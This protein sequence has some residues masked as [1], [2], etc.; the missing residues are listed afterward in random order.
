M[1]KR[2]IVVISIVL[3]FLHPW[4]AQASS[5]LP[6]APDADTQYKISIDKD[7]LYKITYNALLNAGV[8]VDTIDPRYFHLRNGNQEIPI[9]LVTAVPGDFVAGDYF[10][11]YGQKTNTKYTDTNVYWLS[12]DNL[13]GLTMAASDGNPVSGT[14]PANFLTTLH[15][16]GNTTYQ[17]SYPSGVDNDHWY[18]NG[19]SVSTS[20]PSKSLNFTTTLNNLSSGSLTATIRGLLKGNTNP[21]HHVKIY[22][23]STQIKDAT[24]V[25][26]VDYYFSINVPQASLVNGTNTIT[27]QLILDSGSS[28]L[29]FINWFKIN[30]YDTYV[31]ESNLLAFD[32]DQPGDTQLELTGYSSSDIEVYDITVPNVPV[33]VI[34]G[35]VS[36]PG[37]VTYQWVG[38]QTTSQERRYLALTD[39]ARL[40][41]LRIQPDSPSN[42][43][44]PNNGADWIA[45]SYVDFMPEAQRL[46][47]FRGSY[48]GY[49]TFVVDVQD[50]YDEFSAGV[51]D[52]NAIHDFLYYAYTQWQ[53]PKPRFV[54]LFGDGHYDF[55]N[56]LGYNEPSWIPPYLADVDPYMGETAADN[57]YVTLVDN[58]IKPDMALG[59]L[60]A[61]SLADATAMVDKIINYDQTEATGWNQ[62]VSFVADDY[63]PA[64]G[65]FVALS[66]SIADYYL[67][68]DYTKD[69]IYYTVAPNTTIATTQAAILNAMNAG[70]LLISYVGHGSTKWWAA[71]KLLQVT[72]LASLSN[73]DRLPFMVPMTCLE[74]YYITPT[75]PG[76]D[77]SSLG[78]SI[79]RAAAKGAIASWSPTGQGVAVGHDILEKGLF[80]AL[81]SLNLTQIGTATVYAK[82]YLY[83]HSLTH[84]DLID[85]YILFGDP[86]TRL[87]TYH[88]TPTAVD[89]AAPFTAATLPSG[90]VQLTWAT[91]Q[92]VTLAGFNIYREESGQLRQKLNQALIPAQ[93]TGTQGSVYSFTDLTAQPAVTYTY[94]LEILEVDG[95]I[96]GPLQAQWQRRLFLPFAFRNG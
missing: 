69:K 11:F 46:A 13:L 80:E 15:M 74:G 19:I 59:R 36:S 22:L 56:Y 26:T 3:S 75:R 88:P 68:A 50:V 62:F 96:L 40:S 90:A 70:R 67:P 48:N 42:L 89:L 31:A 71:E 10:L 39:A 57:R 58:D 2:S 5:I 4:L 53:E 32:I 78:E 27:V 61:R 6:T 41:P 63:D 20:A 84:R 14:K 24:F 55:K 82:N 18:W 34:N 64:A 28:D 93:M 81:F 86:A 60:P 76:D 12:W 33:R 77:T 66:D 92:E 47:N 91:A 21:S 44:N 7:G 43:S 51:F 83:D 45:I 9:H 29:I 17:R 94:W 87:K 8:P 1:F 30:Y 54:L 49:R 38:R 16:E 95:T 79:V 65:D 72:S 73:A 85:T 52:P 37:G 35:V 25:S 23:N